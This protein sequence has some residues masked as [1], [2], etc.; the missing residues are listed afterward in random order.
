MSLL[1]NWVEGKK[2]GSEDSRVS[3][4]NMRDLRQGF[5]RTARDLEDLGEI[6][7]SEGTSNIERPASNGEDEKTELLKSPTVSFCI[8]GR[9][10]Q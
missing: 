4:T 1:S 5:E 7:T 9:I 3:R 2:T 6:N 8:E 10:F